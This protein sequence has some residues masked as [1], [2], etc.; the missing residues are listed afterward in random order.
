MDLNF[1]NFEN[2]NST[3]EQS[4][5]FGGN[6]GDR[7]NLVGSGASLSAPSG[8]VFDDSQSSTSTRKGNFFSF[9]YYQQFFDVETDQVIKRLLNSVVPTHRNYIQDF[10]QPIPDLWGPFWVS[11]TLVFA[12]GIFGNLA[13]FIENDGA[14]GTY[15]S[16]FRMVTSASTLIFLYVVIVPLLLYG[17]LWNRRS[18]LL[19]PYVD[20]VCLYGYSLT[21]FI[22]VT[23]LWIIDIGWFRWALI[24]MSV[25]LSG[26]VLARAIWPAVQ[27]DVN[28]MVAFGT[29]ITVVVLHFLLAFTFKEF[30]FD[31][32]H[33][34]KSVVPISPT[35]APLDITTAAMIQNATVS[36]NQ[37]KEA[38]E[39]PNM[40]AN[41]TKEDKES[42]R[43][44]TSTEPSHTVGTKDEKVDLKPA[45][46]TVKPTEKATL[47]TA[48]DTYSINMEQYEHF[49]SPQHCFVYFPIIPRRN[50]PARKELDAYSRY[51][52]DLMIQ[53]HGL[54]VIQR[55]PREQRNLARVMTFYEHELSYLHQFDAKNYNF[56]QEEEKKIENIDTNQV[57]TKEAN[58]AELANPESEIPFDN[59]FAKLINS[60]LNK[61]VD[62]E[63]QDTKPGNS[64]GDES[65]LT[66]STE[67]VKAFD[68]EPKTSDNRTN[69]YS[70]LSSLL[71]ES[72]EASWV[73]NSEDNWSKPSLKT[74]LVPNPAFCPHS[75]MAK[76]D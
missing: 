44:E 64:G 61:Q 42:T 63:S 62:A 12:I 65:E 2:V 67:H 30:Y 7:N 13:Q 20:L 43:N 41:E 9:E 35:E 8:G 66:V 46:T 16:D 4:G 53:F 3:N 24:F 40:I 10:L 49:Y 32:M 58:S 39:A 14:K 21:I 75:D 28:K 31:A 54:P 33:P 55:S 38:P 57:E 47:A 73:T 29:I 52:M 69:S 34:A 26:T 19:H 59:V 60:G 51:M 71:E 48:T 23:F 18:E 5:A 72:F 25:G 50:S 37:T 6:I 56:E 76:D 70:L 1:Q 15:G 36:S 22:P 11:V 27:N 17:L 45:N 68:T 74:H